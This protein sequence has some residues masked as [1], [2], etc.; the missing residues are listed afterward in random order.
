MFEE[1]SRQ[2][3]NLS[4]EIHYLLRRVESKQDLLKMSLDSY[5]NQMLRANVYLSVGAVCLATSTTIAGYFGMNLLHGLETDENA[6]AAVVA[7]TGGLSGCVFL[8]CMYYVNSS[9]ISKTAGT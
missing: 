1:Y 5:R 3:H 2:L 8:W 4:Q 6:F 9:R 7:G